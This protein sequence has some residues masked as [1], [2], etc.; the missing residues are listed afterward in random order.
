[1]NAI[2]SFSDRRDENCLILRTNLG[3]P[4]IYWEN[5][6]MSKRLMIIGVMLIFSISATPAQ[7]PSPEALAVARSL[8]STM[9]LTDQYKALLPVILL[10]IKP[11][12]VQGRPEIERDYDAMAAQIGDAYAPYYSSMVDS[13]ASLYASNFT[14]DELREI[15]AFYRLPVGQKLLQKS[16]AITQ[17]SMQIGQDA[18]R[19]AAEDLRVRLTDLL[20]QKGHKM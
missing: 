1:V 6:L 13:A 20:R 18:S 17:Q 10:S 16:L 15:D 19:K 11:A 8:I 14:V 9:K 2:L 3:T 7:T 12:L 5:K 4:L